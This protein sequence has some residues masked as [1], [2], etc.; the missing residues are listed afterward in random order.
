[1]LRTADSPYNVFQQR[2]GEQARIGDSVY[3]KQIALSVLRPEAAL[4]AHGWDAGY[5]FLMAFK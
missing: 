1:M 4:F 3:C 2:Q 5:H